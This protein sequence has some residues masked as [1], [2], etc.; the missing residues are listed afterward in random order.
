MP[1]LPL[2]ILPFRTLHLPPPDSFRSQTVIVTGSNTGIGLETARHIVSLGASKVILGIRILSKGLSAKANIESSTGR[3]GI[4]EV[5]ELDLESFASVKAFASR[6]ES[7][8]RL[9][10]AIMNAGLASLQWNLAPDGWERQLQVN[11]LS[12]TLLSLL[13][14]PQLARSKKSVSQAQPHLVLVGSDVHLDAKFS[15]RSSE[16]ILAELNKKDTWEKSAA[17]GGPAERYNVSKLLDLYVA[18]ELASLTTSV[19]VNIVAP[20]F[21]KSELLAREPGAPWILT[22]LQALTARSL[23]EG[24]KTLVDAAVWGREPH[25][26]YLDHQ[27]LA[28]FVTGPSPSSPNCR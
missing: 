4:V 17:A 1:L 22:I 18:I 25:G 8:D 15:E 20:G 28:K 2:F 16:N 24:S 13:L 10:T 21:C 19:V 27:K 3:T 5:W 12:T 14:L 11:V 26:K 7:L 6:A 9:D 23:P